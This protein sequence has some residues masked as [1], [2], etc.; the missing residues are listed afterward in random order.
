MK[1]K[2]VIALLA[3]LF[4][5]FSGCKGGG[6]AVKKM[7]VESPAFAN[8]EFIPVKYTGM[9]EDVS[10]PLKWS[11]APDGTKS[12]AIVMDDPD[13][14]IGV[15]THWIIFDIPADQNSL[16]EGVPRVPVL[17]NG[18]KQGT[19]DF[20]R[21]GYNGPMPP[22]GK[23]HHY[24]IKIYALDFVPNISPGIRAKALFTAIKGHVIAEGETVGLFKR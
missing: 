9:G 2:I 1:A 21:I 17:E 23:V 18:A 22:P 3:L 4:I 13:A 8:G 15:F 19:N 24:H 20:G 11:G 5:A 16:E 14:P 12:F 7:N 10:V 6:A